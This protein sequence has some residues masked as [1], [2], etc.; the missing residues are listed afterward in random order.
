MESVCEGRPWDFRNFHES[1]GYIMLIYT[2]MFVLSLLSQM[3]G[4]ETTRHIR[5]WELESCKECF[6]PDASNIL[7]WR[8]GSGCQHCRIPIVAVTADVMKGTHDLCFEAGMDHYI[9]KVRFLY[10]CGSAIQHLQPS[11]QIYINTLKYKP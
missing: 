6:I 2:E 9:S 5:Q 3:D 1:M 8:D 10:A 4:Y 11:L 7:S